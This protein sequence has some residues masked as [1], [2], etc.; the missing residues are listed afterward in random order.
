[1]PKR[2]STA[3]HFLV[4]QSAIQSVSNDRWLSRSQETHNRVQEA[5]SSVSTLLTQRI[6][7]VFAAYAQGVRRQRC[8]RSGKI[9]RELFGVW[10]LNPQG[11]V[12]IYLLRFVPHIL[13]PLNM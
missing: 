1:M 10:P 4:E 2:C 9:M 8:R 12:R 11:I 7:A 13:R 6:R 3:V 5:V